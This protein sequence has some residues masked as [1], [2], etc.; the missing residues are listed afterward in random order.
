MDYMPPGYIQR[1]GDERFPRFVIRDGVGQCWAGEE[2]R[3]RDKPSEA[4]LFH[5]RGSRRR[6][7]EPPLPRRR[8]GGHVRRDGH[9]D[10]P[11][12]PVVGEGAHPL[13]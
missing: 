6:G 11:R 5:S 12:P 9:G 3:W 13:T 8:S 7:T 4:V 2:R 10:R 1:V